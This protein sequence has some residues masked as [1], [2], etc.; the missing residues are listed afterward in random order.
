MQHLL[1]VIL[2]L[3]ILVLVTITIIMIFNGYH[4]KLMKESLPHVVR[5]LYGT[6]HVKFY[7]EVSPLRAQRL[8]HRNS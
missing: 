2:V 8:L 5:L 7:Q 6:V 1:Q 3:T 4:G